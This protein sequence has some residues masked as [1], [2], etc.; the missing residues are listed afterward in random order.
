[1][2]HQGAQLQEAP[3]ANHLKISRGTRSA[4]QKQWP[5]PYGRVVFWARLTAGLA[6]FAPCPNC[7]LR[8]Q[9]CGA[10][11]MISTHGQPTIRGAHLPLSRNARKW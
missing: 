2:A 6:L 4:T 5:L 8:W 1:M 11:P 9:F 7:V 10:L 3:Q